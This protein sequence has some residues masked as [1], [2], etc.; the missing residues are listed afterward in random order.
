MTSLIV[1]SSSAFIV[2][3][4]H[5]SFDAFLLYSLLTLFVSSLLLPFGPHCRLVSLTAWRN[6]LQWD[7]KNSEHQK[8]RDWWPVLFLMC[9]VASH[10]MC[11]KWFLSCWRPIWQ[12]F[13][14]AHSHLTSLCFLLFLHSAGS[15]FYFLPGWIRIAWWSMSMTSARV[16]PQ[17]KRISVSWQ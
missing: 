1:L 4:K 14:H 8:L 7:P 3:H 15:C 13:T 16:G 10:S 2:F 9:A 12:W 17:S 5:H 6:V 11:T